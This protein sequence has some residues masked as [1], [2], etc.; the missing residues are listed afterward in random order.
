MGRKRRI[1]SGILDVL[2][3]IF[4]VFVRGMLGIAQYDYGMSVWYSVGFDMWVLGLVAI[5]IIGKRK[6]AVRAA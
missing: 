4:I 6:R 2:A 3:V 5:Y 1:I